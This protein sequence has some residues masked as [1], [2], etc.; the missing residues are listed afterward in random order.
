MLHRHWK[1]VGTFRASPWYEQSCSGFRNVIFLF[2]DRSNFFWFSS[3]SNSM[4]LR[5]VFFC[6]LKVGCTSITLHLISRV[7][8]AF[9]V[10]ELTQGVKICRYMVFFGRRFDRSL[11][12]TMY[13][14]NPLDNWS[15]FVRQTG[16]KW[17]F[18]YIFV[19]TVT[20]GRAETDFSFFILIIYF[21]IYKY[22]SVNC[23]MESFFQKLSIIQ[24]DPTI[25]W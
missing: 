10:F 9:E 1:A 17:S 25:F 6:D 23:Y 19:Y 7:S 16:E 12:D 2:Q 14:Y 21:K 5:Y 8:L 18:F 15:I 22:W 4:F 20:V 11:L 3:L 24:R 13:W